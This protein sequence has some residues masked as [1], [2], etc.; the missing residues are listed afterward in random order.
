F[1]QEGINKNEFIYKKHL[2]SKKLLKHKKIEKII[3]L[4]IIIEFMST[5]YNTNNIDNTN[6]G[7]SVQ[8]SKKMIQQL[9]Q[10]QRI[11]SPE[12][13]V[14]NINS[15]SGSPQISSEII[16]PIPIST[17]K[18]SDESIL[19]ASTTNCLMTNSASS[20]PV[21]VPDTKSPMISVPYING[22]IVLPQ[23]PSAGYPKNM[24][25]QSTNDIWS[26]WHDYFVQQYMIVGTLLEKFKEELKYPPVL[27]GKSD[28]IRKNEICE[29]LFKIIDS[30][31]K[32]TKDERVKKNQWYDNMTPTKVTGMIAEAHTPM[33]LLSFFDG[34]TF[35]TLRKIID[36]ACEVLCDFKIKSDKKVE[37]KSDKKVEVKSDKKDEVKSDKKDEVKSDKK[38]EVKS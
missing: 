18:P 27:R 19:P 26:I 13:S 22:N 32:E 34:P 3:H 4:Q 25:L 36:E 16:R 20:S 24:Y 10:D 5:I 28:D 11:A 2:I 37:V 17:P 8:R 29:N 15:R 30:I 23:N 38:D 33:E 7:W 12:N 6:E 31:L 21:N 14:S 1:L 35:P 9:K